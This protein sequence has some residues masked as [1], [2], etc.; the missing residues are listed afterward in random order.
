MLGLGIG[1]VFHRKV[2]KS[3]EGSDYITTTT[4][5]GYSGGSASCADVTFNALQAIESSYLENDFGGFL[6]TEDGGKIIL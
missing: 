4:A 2:R 6:V 3:S 5:E 1:L